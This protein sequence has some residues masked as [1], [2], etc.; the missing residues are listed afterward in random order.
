MRSVEQLFDDLCEQRFHLDFS[1]I[2]LQRS[3]DGNLFIGPGYICQTVPQDFEIKIY[4][5]G[6]VDI[7]K[8]FKEFQ[9]V[10]TGVFYEKNDHYRLTA[11]DI[12]G[13]RWTAEGIVNPVSCDIRTASA[14]RRS[15]ASSSATQSVGLCGSGIDTSLDAAGSPC[16]RAAHSPLRPRAGTE[17]P[18]G[19][20]EASELF[21]QHILQ[22]RFVQG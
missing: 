4:A 8:W 18:G 21:C 12:Y 1:R 5:K 22:H 17:P 19:V 13:R 14:P 15:P 9:S 2:E 16:R 20:A 11:T 3:R 6:R 7:H 10:K